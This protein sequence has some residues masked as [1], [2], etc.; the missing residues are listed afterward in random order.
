MQGQPIKILH[1]ISTLDVGGAEQNLLRLISSMDKTS[2]DSSVVSMTDIGPIGKECMNRGFPVHALNMKKGIPDPR[3]VSRLKKFVS[4]VQPHIMQC[5][6]YH[7]N[8]LGLLF[9]RGRRLVWNIRCS[10]MDLTQYDFIY[11]YT[12]KS[13]A[14][15]SRIP[16]A[17]IANSCAGKAYHEE[18]GYSSR[19]WEIIP[20]GFDMDLFKPDVNA[21]TRVRRELSIPEDAPVIGLIARHDPMKD[22]R[23]FFHAACLHLETHPSVHFILA[24]QNVTG[25]NPELHR[26]IGNN[27]NSGQF[28][29]LG[30]RRDIPDVLAALDIATSSSLS[31]GLPNTIGEAMATGIPCVVTDVG[32]SRILVGDAGHV[33]PKNSPELLARAWQRLIDAGP[34]HIRLLGGRARKR[35]G[36]HYSLDSSV[37]HYEKLYT[38]LTAT[39][40]T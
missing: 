9:S 31:E 30:Q 35:I 5:W 32:D 7:A 14:I 1:L 20:N 15:F 24:G 8:L 37:R 39:P 26:L 21:R 18:L 27:K 4:H 16:D 6:M 40:V 25:E 13:G 3:G 28:H 38:D 19:R 34:D 11:K 29:L 2:Y 33:V 10:D 17:V 22:H 36:Q 12:V 23:T